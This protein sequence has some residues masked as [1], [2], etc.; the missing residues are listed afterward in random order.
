[1]KKFEQYLQGYHRIIQVGKTICMH[2]LN[3]FNVKYLHI[4]AIPPTAAAFIINSAIVVYE[5]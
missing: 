1:V 5:T 4:M 2:I 3:V